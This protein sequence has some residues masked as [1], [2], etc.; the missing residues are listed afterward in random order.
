[1]SRSGRRS[2]FSILFGSKPN[3]FG[4]ILI[5]CFLVVAVQAV[6][7]LEVFRH[8]IQQIQMLDTPHPD[9]AVAVMQQ[10]TTLGWFFAITIVALCAVCMFLIRFITVNMMGAKQAI[11]N[12]L[13]QLKSGNLTPFRPLRPEDE[14]KDVLASLE[15]FAQKVSMKK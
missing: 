8:A 15:E 4:R 1:M 2:W 12:Y 6:I 5:L 11:L 9:A 3:R 14:F 10:L 13:E 7:C